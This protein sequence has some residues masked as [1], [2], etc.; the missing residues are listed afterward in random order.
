MI[1]IDENFPDSQR[2]LLQGWRVS[3]KQIAF[4]NQGMVIVSA[5]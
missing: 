4:E 5:M 1:L 2:Q 3:L